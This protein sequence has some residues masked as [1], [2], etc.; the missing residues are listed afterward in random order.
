MGQRASF[1]LARAPLQVAIDVTI[2]EITLKDDLQYGVQYYLQNYRAPT[3]R[4]RGATESSSIGF[5]LGDPLARAFPGANFVL[6]TNDDPKIVLSAL[7][8][9]TDVKVLSAPSLVVLDNQ[10]AV[11]Q[12]GDQ[13]PIITQQATNVTTASPALVNSIERHDTGVILKVIP[14]VNANGVVNLDVSQE[15]SAVATN[16]PALGPTISQR[17]VQSSVAVASGQTVLLGGLISSNQNNTRNG[18]PILSD[19]K[20]VGDLFAQTEKKNE[21]TELIVFI[22]PQIIRNGVDAQLVAEELRSKLQTLARGAAQQG[23]S[24]SKSIFRDR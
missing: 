7:K 1:E 2:A 14:R 11:L 19:L 5:G 15:V 9:V 22:R 21:R 20:G 4:G 10:P 12:V 3:R 16:D 23:Q 17:K 8:T 6:G 18:I 13:V 24:D